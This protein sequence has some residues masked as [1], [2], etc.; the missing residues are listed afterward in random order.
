MT[1]FYQIVFFACIALAGVFIQITLPF[2]FPA[3]IISMVLLFLLLLFK[4]VKSE[5]IAL[6][7]KTLIKYMGLFFV[8]PTIS[9]IQYIYMLEGYLLKFALIAVLA[10]ICTFIASSRAIRFTLFLMNRGQHN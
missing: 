1:L 9:V 10:T 8:V 7:S 6:L 2:A 3:P 4:V 5:S